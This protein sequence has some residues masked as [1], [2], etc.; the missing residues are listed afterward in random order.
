MTYWGRDG[1]PVPGRRAS[2]AALV[3]GA[4]LR[5]ML[6]EVRLQRLE[7]PRRVLG[8]ADLLVPLL[9][10]QLDRIDAVWDM[11]EDARDVDA[12]CTAGL[13]APPW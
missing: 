4:H 13:I 6:G 2:G 9:V 1:T 5:R 11:R 10:G 12:A 7:A 3:A 8:I